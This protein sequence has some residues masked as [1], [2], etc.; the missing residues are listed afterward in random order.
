MQKTRADQKTVLSQGSLPE[1][2][3]G[4]G[5]VRKRERGQEGGRE[6]GGR[7]RRARKRESKASAGENRVSMTTGLAG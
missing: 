2:S 7:G 6:E 1:L 5:V 3:W 4:W